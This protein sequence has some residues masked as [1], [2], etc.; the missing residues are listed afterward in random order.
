MPIVAD[1]DLAQLQGERRGAPVSWRE[2]RKTLELADHA[3]YR[4]FR[5]KVAAE[6]SFSSWVG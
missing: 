3:V 6:P 2:F 1:L 5:A 4:L